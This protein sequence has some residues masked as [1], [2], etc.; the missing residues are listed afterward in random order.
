MSRFSCIIFD[1]DGTLTRTNELIYATFNHVAE[2]YLNRV[3]TPVE[4]TGMFGPP[5]DVAI[6]K[7]VGSERLDDAMDDFYDFYE[8]H[9]P[10]MAAA[11]EGVRELLEHVKREGVVLALF[12]GKGKRSTLIT[13][14]MLGIASYFDL[15]VTGHDVRSYKPSADGIRRVMTHFGLEPEKVLMVGDAVA[16][17]KAA[18]E[19]GVR[20][21]A[22]LWDSYGKENVMQMD[23][24]YSFHSI[25]EFARWLKETA[26]PPGDHRR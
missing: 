2:K 26:L 10:K 5:E 24:D 1:L 20:M 14:R 18:R 7:L 9:H 25:G 6:G 23:V 16:D 17:V 11:Y 12:T 4:I 8:R 19:A 15:V 13:L 22:A 21:A 3:Y